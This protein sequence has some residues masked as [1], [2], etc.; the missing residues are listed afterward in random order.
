M[1]DPGWL[2][3]DRSDEDAAPR[4]CT[5][6]AGSSDLPGAVSH[7]D[8]VKAGADPAVSY[9]PPAVVPSLDYTIHHARPRS[10]PSRDNLWPG[11]T[12]TSFFPPHSR[13]TDP[14]LVPCPKHRPVTA[15]ARLFPS[16]LTSGDNGSPNPPTDHLADAA[17]P[18]LTSGSAAGHI[19]QPL[20]VSLQAAS[21]AAVTA[22]FAAV[23]VAAPAPAS[24]T[25]DCTPDSNSHL[26]SGDT[27]SSPLRK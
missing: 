14:G 8:G 1:V 13:T 25:A 3:A 2:V 4:E 5:S 7:G 17:H 26:Q 23:D 10:A 18:V 21:A 12:S 9:F 20:A 11:T 16:S 24:A 22:P 6:A 15:G 27:V 19:S